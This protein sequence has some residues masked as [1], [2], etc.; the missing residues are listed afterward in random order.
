MDD[1]RPFFN[2]S[3]VFVAPFTETH[4]SKLK[5]VEAMAM[6]MPIVSTPQGVRGF[7]ITDGREVRIAYSDRQFANLSLELLKS[8]HICEQMG[9][10]GRHMATSNFDW[11]VL[12]YKIQ[13]IVE[14][15]I[16]E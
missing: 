13:D 15:V 3:D 2:S 8:P 16:F 14:R 6:G 11:T 5:I 7:P 9:R 12:G 1:I 4:G 10:L